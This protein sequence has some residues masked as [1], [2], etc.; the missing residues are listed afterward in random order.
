MLTAPRKGPP[1]IMKVFARTS[2][3]VV[4]VRGTA[5]QLDQ[6]EKRYCFY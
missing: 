3:P 6:A 5:A 2:P 4:A 1:S